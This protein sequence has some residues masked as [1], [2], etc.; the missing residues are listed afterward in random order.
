VPQLSLKLFGAFKARLDDGAALTL[1]AKGQALFAYLALHPEQ[2]LSRERLAALLWG[3]MGNEQALRNLRHT[4]FTIRKATGGR[5]TA[6]VAD[7]HAL[8]LEPAIVS[9]D[10]LEFERLIAENATPDALR[11][12]A[13]LYTGDLL[14][15]LQVSEPPFE[16][17]LVTER[18]RFREAA[19]EALGRLLAHETT[20]APTQAAIQIATRLLTL[21]P[22]QEVTGRSCDCTRG[23]G[24]AAP[25][26]N[27]IRRA[28]SCSDASLAPSPSARRS[29]CTGNCSSAAT[30]IRP[31]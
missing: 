27:S 19:V 24:G 28:S 22:L 7:G 8:G 10:A 20:H 15:G 29:S 2:A 9:V 26:S 5:L 25:R 16:E 30:R 14:E 11:A 12:A 17:W 18:E 31:G 13:A 3:D 6:I 1:P 4:V 21:D 23:K